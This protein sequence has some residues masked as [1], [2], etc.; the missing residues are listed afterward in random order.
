MAL[1]RLQ[2]VQN[3]RYRTFKTASGIFLTLTSLGFAA[4]CRC[5]SDLVPRERYIGLS[6]TTLNSVHL[7]CTQEV[8]Y[9]LYYLVAIKVLR[10]ARYLVF[11]VNVY[12]GPALVVCTIAVTDTWFEVK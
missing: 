5:A 8:Y 11:T 3:S 12:T 10:G 6:P 1:L 2:V 4:D 9:F 7:V